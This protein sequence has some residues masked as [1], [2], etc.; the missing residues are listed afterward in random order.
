MG[1]PE[2]VIKS[3]VKDNSKKHPHMR[4]EFTQ[5]KKIGRPKQTWVWD[6]PVR[7]EETD[8]RKGHWEKVR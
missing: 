1:R 8:D 6:E 5:G 7:E 2:G 4:E 3:K